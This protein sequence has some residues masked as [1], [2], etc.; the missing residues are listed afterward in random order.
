MKTHNHFWAT[1]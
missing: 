1:S